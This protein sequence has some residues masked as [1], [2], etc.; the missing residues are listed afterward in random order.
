MAIAAGR[1]LADRIYGGDS[2]AFLDYDNVPTVIFN[3]PPIATVGMSEVIPI[4]LL[5]F[6]VLLIACRGKLVPKPRRKV[7][8]SRFTHRAS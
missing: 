1:K 7:S 4:S 2:G 5:C 3:H 8:R 6:G